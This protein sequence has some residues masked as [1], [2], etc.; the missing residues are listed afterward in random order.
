MSETSTSVHRNDLG[1]EYTKAF[2]AGFSDGLDRVLGL[3]VVLAIVLFVS[4]AVAVDS[5]NR[6]DK[7]EAELAKIQHLTI[8]E[9]K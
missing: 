1:K 7:A 4:T 3:L 2:Q 8:V 6:A 5:R 9:Q